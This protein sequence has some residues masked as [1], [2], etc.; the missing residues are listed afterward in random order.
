MQTYSSSHDT[1]AYLRS[2]GCVAQSVARLT[3]DRGTGFDTQS[4]HIL[5]WKLIKKPFSTGIFSLPLIQ[6]GH[7]PVIGESMGT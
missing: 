1:L 6:E 5:S 3:E 2:P 7:L 4:G